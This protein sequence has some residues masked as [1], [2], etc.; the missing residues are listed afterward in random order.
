MFPSLVR[1]FKMRCYG[2]SKALRFISSLHFGITL[3]LVFLPLYL[4]FFIGKIAKTPHAFIDI[5][6]T[7]MKYSISALSAINILREYL[8]SKTEIVASD[9]TKTLIRQLI[10]L[11]VDCYG[12]KGT[13]RATLFIPRDF[14]REKIVVYDRISTGKGP[15]YD[16]DCF[17]TMGQGLPGLAWK[18]AWSGEGGTSELVKAL[19]FGNVPDN[20][21]KD[22]NSLRRYFRD[23]FKI[24]N[25]KIYESLGQKKTEIKSYMAVGILG[26]FTELSC[27][28]V[29]DSEDENKFT[30]FEQ[31]QIAQKKTLNEAVSIGGSQTVCSEKKKN[32]G[33]QGSVKG[34]EKDI[35]A[36]MDAISKLDKLN[37]D[38][39]WSNVKSTLK[40]VAFLFHREQS[41][42]VRVNAEGFLFPLS[43]T[44]KQVR[45]ILK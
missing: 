21:L 5:A 11:L 2:S 7:T 28:L 23:I 13:C 24:N 14:K 3:S 22:K 20:V 43:W 10:V 8:L 45:E 27:I 37:A 40:Q 38:A 15:G 32:N 31:L 19:H 26:R 36:S 29:V 42:D 44:L 9:Y 33:G 41:T 6:I 16:G 30:D 4:N 34:D 25:D 1:L 18:N 39:G 12:W 17:F 35:A